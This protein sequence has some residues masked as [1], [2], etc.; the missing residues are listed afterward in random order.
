MTWW[1]SRLFGWLRPDPTPPAPPNPLRQ[2]PHP[3]ATT[4]DIAIYQTTTLTDR[5]DRVP[6]QNV[7]DHL[8]QGL[9]DAGYNVYVKHGRPPLALPDDPTGDTLQRF[10][11]QDRAGS[12][13]NV[14]LGDRNGGGLAYVGGRYCLAPAGNID[15]R[16]RTHDQAP[17]DTDTPRFWINLRAAAL[18]EPGHLLGGRHSDVM[19]DPRWSEYPDAPASLLFNNVDAGWMDSPPP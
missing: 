16:I 14:L 11:A 12:D 8:A 13:M 3:D 17:D 15:R 6:E 7:A 19:T 2:S 4:L 10:A 18:H 5:L 9:T 1:C